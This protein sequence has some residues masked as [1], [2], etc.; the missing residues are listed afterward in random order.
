[1]SDNEVGVVDADLTTRRSSIP[2]LR[3]TRLAT[4]RRGELGRLLPDVMGGVSAGA[5]T[6]QPSMAKGAGLLLPNPQTFRESDG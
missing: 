4:L 2:G 1:M 6:S 5:D 3:S